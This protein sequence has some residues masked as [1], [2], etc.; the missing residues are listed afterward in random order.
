[1]KIKKNDNVVVI[2]GNDRGKTGKILKVFPSVS[3]VII[4]GI[5]LRKRHTKPNQKQPQGGIIEKEAP[6]H[7]SNVM[8]I[9]PKTNESTRLGAKI[10][11]D[12]KTGKKKSQRISRTTGEMV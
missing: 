3:K 4:E 10:I 11:L 9:D 12:G 1:M 6:I 2:T 8:L 7:V 5:N